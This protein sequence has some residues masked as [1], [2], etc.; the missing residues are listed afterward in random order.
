MQ[1]P[2]ARKMIAPDPTD[3]PASITGLGG[4]PLVP[5]KSSAELSNSS[6]A[7][8]NG[9]LGPDGANALSLRPFDTPP[10]LASISAYVVPIGTSHTPALFTSPQTLA[11]LIPSHPRMPIALYASPPFFTISGMCVQVS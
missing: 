10:A 2:S 9:K 4:A 6:V 3:P 5:G 11:H 1:R 7:G 8:R